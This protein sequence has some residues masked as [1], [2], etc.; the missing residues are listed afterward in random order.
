[1]TSLA[2]TGGNSWVAKEIA[3]YIVSQNSNIEITFLI[4]KKSIKYYPLSEFSKNNL[5]QFDFVFHLAHEYSSNS[6]V[7]KNILREFEIFLKKTGAS[8]IFLSTMSASKDNPTHYS[9]VKIELEKIFHEH[10]GKVLRS[11]LIYKNL[12]SQN[13]SRPLQKLNRIFKLVPFSISSESSYFLTSIASIGNALLSIIDTKAADDPNVRI[14]KNIFD[15]GPLKFFELQES[16]GI[17]RK[18]MLRFSSTLIKRIYLRYENS[19]QR[20]AW[21]DRIINLLVGMYL[22]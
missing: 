12:E 11:G 7:S 14:E 5:D 20:L 22:E 19:F 1:M 18:P 16:L 2:F 6:T 8:H 10:G 21:F 13:F 3:R 17:K 9:R 4:R 15:A